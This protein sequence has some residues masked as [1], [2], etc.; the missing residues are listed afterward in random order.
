MFSFTLQGV[1]LT[2][3]RWEDVF[4]L[5]TLIYPECG[6]FPDITR[7]KVIKRISLLIFL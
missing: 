6:A 4:N 3:E 1:N 7:V 2:E 5:T